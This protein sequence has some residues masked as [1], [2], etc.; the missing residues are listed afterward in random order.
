M[1]VFSSNIYVSLFFRVLSAVFYPAFISIALTVCE[2]IAPE[3]EKQDYITK[4]LL[5][6]SVGSIVGLPITTGLGTVFGYRVAMLWIFVINFLTLILILLFFPRIP[7]KSKAYEAPLSSL[8]SKKFILASLGIV[9]MPIG[10]SIV[11]NYMPYFLQTVSH[12]YTYNLSILLFVYGLISICGTWL[13]GKLIVY[14]DKATLLIFQLVCG[15]VFVLFYLFAKF[16]IPVLILFLIFSVLDG[17][18]YNLIQYIEA[19]LLPDTPELANG[20]FLSILNGGIA[21]GIAIGGFLVD[22]FGVM[23][24]FVGGTIFLVLAFLMLFYVINILKINLKYA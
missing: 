16:L 14:R 10:A 1:I 2:E 8:K 7:G 17:M 22:G 4:I 20:V 23:S 19:S 15:S 13:S 6:I 3:G 11:Y 12:I 24:I 21:L 9:M 5:G 18:G